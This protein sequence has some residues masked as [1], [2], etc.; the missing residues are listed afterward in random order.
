MKRK[1]FHIVTHF[2]IGGSETV[3]IN[4]SKADNPDYEF[5]FVEVV[6]GEGVYSNAFIKD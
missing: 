4:I 3:A 5:H 6:R 1:I 2:D